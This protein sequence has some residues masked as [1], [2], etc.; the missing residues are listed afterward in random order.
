MSKLETRVERLE[1]QTDDPG[2]E[3]II[4]IWERD[5]EPEPGELVISWLPPNERGMADTTNTP[6]GGGK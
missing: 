6:T 5:R 1:A 3:Q 2:R 4:L